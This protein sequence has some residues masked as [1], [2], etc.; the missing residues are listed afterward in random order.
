MS[1]SRQQDPPYVRGTVPKEGG[2][3]RCPKKLGFKVGQKGGQRR[4]AGHQSL[5]VIL[6]LPDWEALVLSLHFLSFFFSFMYVPIPL[7]LSSQAPWL[8]ETC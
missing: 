7:P 4:G 6:L 1:E 5:A 8:G 3:G 2:F